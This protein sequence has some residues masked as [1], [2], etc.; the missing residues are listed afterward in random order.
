[1][2]PYSGCLPSSRSIVW[3]LMLVCFSNTVADF[4]EKTP[5]KSEYFAGIIIEALS[6]I[7]AVI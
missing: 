5:A 3:V 1:M 7:K 2:S 6:V 4:L